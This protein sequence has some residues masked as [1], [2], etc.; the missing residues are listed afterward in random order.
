MTTLLV[1][2]LLGV[3]ILLIATRLS[4]ELRS[5]VLAENMQIVEARAGQLDE[6]IEKLHWQ[7]NLIA[8]DGG[9]RGGDRK[10]MEAAIASLDGKLSREVIGS[11]FAWPDGAIYTSARESADISGSVYFKDGNA[12]TISGVTDF[13][14]SSPVV[15]ET[16]KVPVIVLMKAVKGKD[17]S[18]RGF[19]AFQVSLDTL[20]SLVDGIRIGRTGYGWIVDKKGLM[21]ATEDKDSL[22]K[23]NI[24]DADK[25]GYR[26]LDDLGMRML[27]S[28]SGSG[29]WTGPDHK[30]MTTYF[31]KVSTSSSWTLGLN[32]PTKELDQTANSLVFL[33]F[34]VLAAGIAVSAFASILLARSILKPVKLAAAGFR[35]LAEGDADLTRSIVLERSDEIGD[36]VRDFNAFLA[37]LRSIVTSLKV[38]QADLAGIGGALG[39]SVEG[40]VKSIARISGSID[41]VQRHTELQTASVETSSSAVHEI[42]MNIESLERLIEDQAARVTQASASIEQMVGNI[43]SVAISIDKMAEQFAALSGAS[44]SGM[45]AQ[46]AATEKIKLASELSSSLLEANEVITGI[47][48]QTDLLAM[49]AAIEAAHAGEAGKGFSVVA[50][51][52]R[53][54]AETSGEQSRTIGESLS[55]LEGVIAEVVGSTRDTEAAFALVAARISETDGIVREVRQAMTEQ[56]EGSSQVLEALRAM[57]D[58]TSQVR[59]GSVEMS[60]GNKTILEEMKRLGDTAV[61]VKAQIAA[62]VAEEAGIE[63]GSRAV[64]DLA[65]STRDTIERMDKAI[66]RF[67]V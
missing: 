18:P 23:L 24:T 59:S 43:G 6:L 15:S 49:N 32:V 22:M 14:V 35:M 54:L 61:E 28:D 52:I 60:L 67:K 2:C 58:V 53:R 26:G 10:S 47:S 50:D 44:D 41:D 30:G 9:L 33:L 36:L 34:G 12:N 17:G 45:A 48:S 57:N 46:A 3:A 7:L 25:D 5:I 65:I 39:S 19:V 8:N 13:L 31:N 4:A 16:L 40:T 63:S 1:S 20:S 64:A 37:M 51:E 66:G 29:T 38:A 27:I 55:R 56:R 42:A 62:M 21:I 11:F